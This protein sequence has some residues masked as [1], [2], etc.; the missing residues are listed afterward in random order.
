MEMRNIE[1]G[2]NGGNKYL[3]WKV[4]YGRTNRLQQ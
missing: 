2:S 1:G 3:T 4:Q